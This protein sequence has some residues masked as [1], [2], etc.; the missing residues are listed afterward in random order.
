[1]AIEAGPGHAPLSATARGVMWCAPG[2]SLNPA[3]RPRRRT[4]STAD[5]R[6]TSGMGTTEVWAL[7]EIVNTSTGG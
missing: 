4:Q 2:T 1:M 5:G 6:E 7:A 3:P